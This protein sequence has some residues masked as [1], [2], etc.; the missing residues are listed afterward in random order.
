MRGDLVKAVVFD[1]DG[2]L[3]RQGPVRRAMVARLARRLLAPPGRGRSDDAH[4]RRLPQGPGGAAGG[5]VRRRRDRRAGCRGG[6]SGRAP[7]PRCCAPPST[8]GWRSRPSA[9]SAPSRA[10]R[11]CRHHRATR[12]EGP[13]AG[14]VSDYPAERK[15]EALGVRDHFDCRRLRP[16]H[17]RRLVQAQPA[18]PAGRPRG[19][20]CRA[21]GARCTWVIGPTSM[22][23]RPAA[24]NV[25]CLLIGG[26]RRRATGDTDARID[27]LGQ[28]VDLLEA[29]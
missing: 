13:P 29:R 25:P 5:R 4:A 20:R 23:R 1:V 7:T 18:G 2:T 14:G 16:G 22:R 17:P 24:A 8:G 10:A 11:P 6:R 3:Y 19:A 28:L 27:T 21:G 26:S 12:R 15:L 9:S